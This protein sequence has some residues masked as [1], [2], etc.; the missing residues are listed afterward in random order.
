MLYLLLL[1]GDLRCHKMNMTEPSSAWLLW[2]LNRWLTLLTIVNNSVQFSR[3]VVSNS[4]QPHE[5]QHARPPCPSPTPWSLLKLMSI[6]SVM[7][8]SHFM[9]C[10]PFL[11]LPSI[12]PS[13]TI[14]SNELI[15]WIRWLKYWSIS[16]SIISSKEHPGLISFRMDWLDLLSVQGTSC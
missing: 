15:L 6:E 7:P 1:S 12:F 2:S 8:S 4:L 11:L 13:I 14:F 16:F 5:P 10:H 9:L 3:S